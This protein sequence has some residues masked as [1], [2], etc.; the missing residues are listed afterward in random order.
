MV[1]LPSIFARLTQ[2]A[3]QDQGTSM[4]PNKLSSANRLPLVSLK[5]AEVGEQSSKLC[6]GK[7]KV[8]PSKGDEVISELVSLGLPPEPTLV[9]MDTELLAEELLEESPV[10][11]GSWEPTTLAMP[12]LSV[13]PGPVEGGS[14]NR[15]DVLGEAPETRC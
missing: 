13:M 12:V 4:S 14:S 8:D 2:E 10:R 1:R 15:F 11:L 6:K 3:S 7:E 9:G 5:T